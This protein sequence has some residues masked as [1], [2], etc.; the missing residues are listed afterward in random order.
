MARG[1]VGARPLLL[2]IIK[3]VISYIT[4]IKGRTHTIAYSA[5][6]YEINNNV[7]PNFNN[8]VNKFNISNQN[9]NA[10]KKHDVSSI[11]QENYDRRWGVYIRNSTKAISYS[12]FKN[13][14]YF[15]KYL[16]QIRNTKNR[17]ALTR[18]RLSNHNLLI[19]KGRHVRPRLE[20]SERRC[21]L[22]KDEIE[23]EK[24]F[25]TKCPFYLKER[26]MLFRS[27]LD[28]STN[29]NSLVSDEQK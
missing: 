3:K 28:N 18:F 25:I 11:Y 7:V 16:Y 14:V 23:D 8:Y 2:D 15:E 27:L 19:E 4:N 5:Y 9:I 21:F 13:T 10:M 1:E 26:A 6:V 22:C 12:I 24:H 17:I 20:R 29:F